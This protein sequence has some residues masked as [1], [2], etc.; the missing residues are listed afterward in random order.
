MPPLVQPSPLDTRIAELGGPSTKT[1][2]VAVGDAMRR[3]GDPT[4]ARPVETGRALGALSVLD[5][6]GVVR[7][8]DVGA[9]RAQL[10]RAS[11]DAFE[12]AFAEAP[13]ERT[14]FAS[15]AVDGLAARDRVASIC[16]AAERR[17][18]MARDGASD[19]D[20]GE[21]EGAISSL[22]ARLSD[23]DRGRERFARPLTGINAER[24]A[25]LARLSDEA[26]AE[27]W[28]FAARVDDDDLLTV[29][30][31][32]GHARGGSSP[33]VWN[34]LLRSKLPAFK[35][36]ERQDVLSSAL[37]RA[38]LGRTHPEE[39]SLLEREAARDESLARALELTTAAVDEE[40]GAAG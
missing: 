32:G 6:A 14:L 20:A 9:C 4:S 12:A 36:A 11:A 10:E 37:A 2:L 8:V 21:L 27:A 33:A 35:G 19:P 30:A 26:R 5:V 18:E 15:A 25:E 1:I 31:D 23:L 22:R 17:L 29:L 34:D 13:D 40:E 38:A 16:V 3:P 24:R 7:D 28:W 39:R